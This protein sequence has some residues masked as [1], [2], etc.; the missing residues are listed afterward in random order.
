MSGIGDKFTL[1][2]GQYETPKDRDNVRKRASPE[3]QPQSGGIL[4]GPD[5]CQCLQ[6]KGSLLL[7]LEP[8]TVVWWGP[9]LAPSQPLLGKA[10]NA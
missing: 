10:V 7:R 9:S 2:Q 8:Q 5:P 4:T 1:L 3:S 6:F